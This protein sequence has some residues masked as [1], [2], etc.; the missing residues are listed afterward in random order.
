MKWFENQNFHGWQ[1][2]DHDQLRLGIVDLAEHTRTALA[3]AIRMVVRMNDGIDQGKKSTNIMKV[4]IG[5]TQG[6]VKA[7]GSPM[8]KLDTEHQELKE[9]NA[10]HEIHLSKILQD[11]ATLEE[12]LERT[13]T[14]ANDTL[15]R[16]EAVVGQSVKDQHLLKAAIEG[17]QHDGNQQGD[18][19]LQ[20]MKT[21]ESTMYGS[22]TSISQRLEELSRASESL[23]AHLQRATQD[24]ASR[25]DPGADGLSGTRAA[26]TA[27]GTQ[28]AAVSS[29]IPLGQTTDASDNATV[30]GMPVGRS[31]SVGSQPVTGQRIMSGSDI[32]LYSKLAEVKDKEDVPKYD[33]RKEG[34]SWRKNAA[35]FLISR[36][37]DMK[38]VFDRIES[39]GKTDQ[40]IASSDFAGRTTSGGARCETLDFL[41]WGFLSAN[42]EGDAWSIL[43]SLDRRGFEVWRRLIEDSV[44]KNASERLHMEGTVLRPPQC[45]SHKDVD[46]A[47]LD[48]ELAKRNWCAVGGRAISAEEESG[49]IL[50]TLP[51]DIRHKAI[52]V[53]MDDLHA[54]PDRLKRLVKETVKLS[55]ILNTGGINHLGSDNEEEYDEDLNELLSLMDDEASEEELLAVVRRAWQKRSKGK[56]QGKGEGKGKSNTRIPSSE[57]RC[58]KCGQL[59]HSASTCPKPA[60]DAKDRACFKCGKKGH[61]AAECRSGAAKSL[62]S[63]EEESGDSVP[64]YHLATLQTDDFIKPKKTAKH[65]SK[66]TAVNPMK[67]SLSDFCGSVFHQA[68]GY[69]ISWLS[70]RSS[71]SISSSV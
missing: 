32:N 69:R 46:K 61:R 51:A 3:S 66:H 53:H 36:C 49:I 45:K 31:A 71:H 33:W 59:G 17:R 5:Q 16:A 52:F 64:K 57:R 43:G 18:H 63:Q 13:K 28:G 39:K 1:A 40:E 14:I 22:S 20:R 25:S 11:G 55:Q 68:R 50:R 7:Q 29:A 12:R 27:A 62:E 21:I 67:V 44:R 4:E 42:L 37:P 26:A 60:V 35:H 65:P 9:R 19:L 70:R 23:R 48:F 6:A 15:Q 47:L 8:V 41:P 30:W 24:G 54:D 58:A 56:G 38:G 34:G 2:K 10:Q